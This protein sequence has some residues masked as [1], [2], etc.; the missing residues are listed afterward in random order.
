MLFQSSGTVVV[1]SVV[2]VWCRVFRLSSRPLTI[3]INSP[4]TNA[5][6]P[7]DLTEEELT[8]NFIHLFPCLSSAKANADRLFVR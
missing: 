2:V 8:S 5:D 4:E 6:K 3:H 1:I 7:H